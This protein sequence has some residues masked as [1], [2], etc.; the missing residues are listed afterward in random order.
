MEPGS[1]GPPLRLDHLPAYLEDKLEH[2]QQVLDLLVVAQARGQATQE[3]WDKLHA[4]AMR[5][6]RTTELCFAYERLKEDRRV[7]IMP[8]QHQAE[9]FMQASRFLL[10]DMGDIEGAQSALERVLTLVP[11]N[12]DAFDRLRRILEEKGDRDALANLHMSA[13]GPKTDRDVALLHLRAALE[14]LPPEDAERATKV[15]QQILRL[16]PSDAGAL[17]AIE[18]RLAAAGKYPELAKLLEQALLADPGPSESRRLDIRRKLL[19]LYD[20]KVPEIERAVPHIEEVLAS[21]P[22]NT[23]ARRVAGRLLSHRALGSR[24]AAALERVYE[25]E[26]DLVSVAQMLNAQ[27]EQLRGPKKAEAQRKLGIIQ[28]DSGEDLAAYQNFEAVLTVDPADDGAR[29]R[30]VVLAGTLGRQGQGARRS[31]ADQ[32]GC[33]SLHG[34]SRRSEASP[35]DPP[36]CPGPG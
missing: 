24:V 21:D 32:P 35:R 25:A 33:R 19:E 15:A 2:E 20:E 8:P 1:K 27:I 9:I 34:R 6:D 10:R 12:V 31:R 11:G 30:Y 29:D 3:L 18:V 13:V 14:H 4:A 7:R 26:G 28:Y 23:V 5:D 16:D 22:A 17:D 36:G